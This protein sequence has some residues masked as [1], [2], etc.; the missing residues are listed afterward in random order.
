MESR[1]ISNVLEHQNVRFPRSGAP[2]SGASRLPH[3]RKFELRSGGRQCSA[4]MTRRGRVKYGCARASLSCHSGLDI[5]NNIDLNIFSYIQVQKIYLLW[6][7][8]YSSS[9]WNMAVRKS[10]GSCVWSISFLLFFCLHHFQQTFSAWDIIFSP[11]SI[12][13][14]LRNIECLLF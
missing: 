13:S 10:C 2:E 8:M 1:P 11:V 4:E 5:E 7:R 12:C 6:Y 9:F 14:L 3:V